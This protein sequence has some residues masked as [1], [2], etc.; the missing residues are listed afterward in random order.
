[1]FTVIEFLPGNLDERSHRRDPAVNL[2]II[3]T[4]NLQK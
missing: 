2:K 4:R 3:L 1:M